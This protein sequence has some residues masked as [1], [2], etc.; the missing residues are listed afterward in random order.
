[1][2]T[3]ATHSINLSLNILLVISTVNKKRTIMV[4]SFNLQKVEALA[5]IRDE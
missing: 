2:K 1:M 4:I 3:L 5:K